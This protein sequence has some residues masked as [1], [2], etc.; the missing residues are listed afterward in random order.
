MIQL[1]L[2]PDVKVEYIKSRSQKRFVML[3]ATIVIIASLGVTA[4]LGLVVYGWQNVR[5]SSLKKSIDKST[6]TLK[7]TEDLNEILTVQNQLNSLDSVHSEKPVMTRLFPYLA[8]SIPTDVKLESISLDIAASTIT[9]TG[10]ASNL[11]SVNK[12][13]DTMKFAS[14]LRGDETSSDTKAFSKVVLTGFT[15]T[16]DKA[17]F[18][19]TMSYDPAIFNSAETDIKLSVPST[20]TTRST[21]EQPGS[22]FQQPNAS[23]G[24]Q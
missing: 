16:S 19:I 13:V 2:L 17:T 9:L 12:L 7:G 11:E 24:Q 18:T 4:F 3:V 22:L 15:T 5:L 8:Q 6:S 23:G 21:T 10:S 1:N 14:L 20:V